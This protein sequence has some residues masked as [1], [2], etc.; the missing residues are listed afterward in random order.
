MKKKAQALQRLGERLVALNEKQVK[1]LVL[2]DELKEAVA[3]VH[4]M[5]SHEARRR[6]LQ[7]IGRLMREIDALAV[8]AAIA[9]L[10]SREN[11]ER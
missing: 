7:Y 4:E 11:R 9:K 10:Q 5:K 6:Q 2:P 8:E 1:A 3:L